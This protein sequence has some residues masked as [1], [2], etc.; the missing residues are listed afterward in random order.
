M[1]KCSKCGV[2]K[3]L[4]GF[5]RDSRRSDGRHKHCKECVLTRVAKYRAD[6]IDKVRAAQRLS[7]QRRPDVYRNKNLKYNY[8][9][10]L[11]DYNQMLAEQDG[12]CAICRQPET[13]IHP[14]S[15]QTKELAV[16]HCHTTGQVRGLLCNRC[17]TTIGLFNDD[18]TVIEA[19][20]QYLKTAKAPDRSQGQTP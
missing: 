17:N 16:D 18:P 12:R 4:D 19:A 20:A 15:G 5:H 1:K 6:N 8:G 2:E 3:S 10:T 7:K 13:M 14:K 11:D 9:I